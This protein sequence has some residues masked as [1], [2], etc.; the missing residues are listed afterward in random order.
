MQF[1]CRF[2]CGRRASLFFYCCPTRICLGVDDS[3]RALRVLGNL[4]GLAVY[5]IPMYGGDLVTVP[6]FCLFSGGGKDKSPCSMIPSIKGS[7][8]QEKRTNLAGL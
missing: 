7:Q 2:G 5:F 1:S 6:E 3:S 4:G 8:L